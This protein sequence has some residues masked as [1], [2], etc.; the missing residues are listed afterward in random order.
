MSDCPHIAT[1]LK[2]NLVEENASVGG[3]VTKASSLVIP[4]SPSLNASS[5]SLGERGDEPSSA[6]MIDFD[7]NHEALAR[8]EV[9]S[10]IDDGIEISDEV[11]ISDEI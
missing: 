2:G 9:K 6:K 3:D 10:C 7:I 4:L 5:L 11:E 8:D 1:P